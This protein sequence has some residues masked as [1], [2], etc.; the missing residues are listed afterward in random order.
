EERVVAEHAAAV[1]DDADEAASAG[2]DVDAQVRGAG[3]Q[4]IFEELFDDG[5]RP[6]HHFARRDFVGDLVG[7][8]ADAAHGERIAGWG[9][10]DLPVC[11]RTGR[12]TCA[13]VGTL[14]YP[15][16]D[17]ESACPNQAAETFSNPWVLRGLP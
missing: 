2:F 4:G 14:R 15:K 17:K 11:A 12:E 13:T 3:V 1:V 9:G 8:N 16:P 7:E 5:S 10:T 6:L